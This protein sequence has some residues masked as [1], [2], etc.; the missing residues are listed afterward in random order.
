M[1]TN[2]ETSKEYL[3]LLEVEREFQSRHS[4]RDVGERGDAK[5]AKLAK[6]ESRFNRAKAALTEAQMAKHAFC[7]V[8]AERQ[9]KSAEAKDKK[10][11][12]IDKLQ[13]KL[14]E[15]RSSDSDSESGGSEKE[16]EASPKKP[17][18]GPLKVP[19]KKGL[20]PQPPPAQ[21]ATNTAAAAPSA[22]SAFQPMQH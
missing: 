12:R 19:L 18:T 21:S 2:V 1:T 11:R 6:A 7:A 13:K 9:Q 3:A 16:E 22:A 20:Q 4:S 8:Y 10:R 5:I 14:K 15:L 17:R